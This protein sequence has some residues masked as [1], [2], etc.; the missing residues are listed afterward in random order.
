MN[1]ARLG[2]AQDFHER[3]EMYDKVLR[4]LS[5]EPVPQAQVTVMKTKRA[6]RGAS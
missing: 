4:V 5:A 2:L 1:L 3:V 6:E